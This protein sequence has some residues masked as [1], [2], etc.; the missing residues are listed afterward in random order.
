[1]AKRQQ[2]A[3]KIRLASVLITL[4][5]AT[6]GCS[7]QPMQTQAPKK[8]A[9]ALQHSN[10]GYE[11]HLHAVLTKAK[12]RQAL[13]L[14][15]TE[16]QSLQ[17]KQ[18]LHPRTDYRINN[19]T[20]NELTASWH[21]LDRGLYKLAS[22]KRELKASLKATADTKHLSDFINAQQDSLVTS[23]FTTYFYDSATKQKFKRRQQLIEHPLE[24]LHHLPQTVDNAHSLLNIEK[25][26]ADLDQLYQAMSSE[27]QPFN[28]AINSDQSQASV[29]KARFNSQIPSPDDLIIN[30]PR[31]ISVMINSWRNED[32][33]KYGNTADF[34][35]NE[36]L[37]RKIIPT[38]AYLLPTKTSSGSPPV[39]AWRDLSKH[40]LREL[41]EAEQT[42]RTKTKTTPRGV[43]YNIEDERKIKQSEQLF[44]ITMMARLR[45]ALLDY[46]HSYHLFNTL[47]QQA[48]L[49]KLLTPQL[50]TTT[51]T[52]QGA[53]LNNIRLCSLEIQTH[54]AYSQLLAS[55]VRVNASTNILN[56]GLNIPSINAKNNNS[57]LTQKGFIGSSK[58]NMKNFLKL[59]IEPIF[60]SSNL[61]TLGL[62]KKPENPQRLKPIQSSVNQPSKA[63]K[64]ETLSTLR[65]K[66]QFNKQAIKKNNDQYGIRLLYAKSHAEF[67]AHRAYSGLRHLPYRTQLKGYDTHYSIYYATYSSK[68][69][70]A[71]GLREI[72]SFYQLFK[73]EIR[74]LPN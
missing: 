60:V 47:K 31:L 23:A 48:K 42:T 63:K 69:A 35:H 10:L 29:I 55:L 49:Q 13:L 4:V 57:T 24:K 65:P 9:E 68:E 64:V 74:Q 70:A 11:E 67:S 52:D 56:Q 3:L 19:A 17:A 14:F 37:W 33:P 72:P 50:S 2:T 66:R 45:I 32:I 20:T 12:T 16:K 71:K 5:V 36:S 26:A 54:L 61:S 51:H 59:E 62:N 73:P 25:Q 28:F 21:L 41:E 38:Y 53:L 39:E 22:K 6:G 40:L 1:M 30:H 27:T 46:A 15:A 43:N 8:P 7:N 18:W 58:P 34:K 44:E